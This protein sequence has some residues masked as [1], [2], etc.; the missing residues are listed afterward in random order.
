MKDNQKSK[1]IHIHQNNGEMN[2]YQKNEKRYEKDFSLPLILFFIWFGLFFCSIF[3]HVYYD[4]WDFTIAYFVDHISTNIENFY[5]FILHDSLDKGMNII[6]YQLIAVAFTGAALSACGSIFQGS[7]RNVLASPSTMG[8][9]AGG[10]LGCI[11]FVLFCGS[12]VSVYNNAFSISMLFQKYL[13]QIMVFGG[14]L[15]GTVFIL[16]ISNLFGKGKLSSS[17]MLLSGMIFSAFVSNIVMIVQYYLLLNDP[18][19]TIVE[20]IQYMMMGSFNAILSLESLLI[21]IIPLSI[22]LILLLLIKDKINILSLGEEEALSLGLNVYFYRNLIVIVGSILT[23]IVVSFVGGIGFI[24]YMVPMITRKLVGPDMKKILPTSMLIGAIY[25]TVVYDI[26]YFLQ[27]ADSMNLVT[28]AIG[29]IVM[30]YTL[31]KKGDHHE[32]IKR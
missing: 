12:S 18:T 15:L 25:L 20:S 30:V 28:S 19:G 8:T 23:A 9:M 17:K 5:H 11:I 22:C 27:L 2:L 13:Q 26:A 14:C 7:M 32:I 4:R 16:L 31:I 24:G 10:R 21:M 3:V 6:V 29:T 1:R